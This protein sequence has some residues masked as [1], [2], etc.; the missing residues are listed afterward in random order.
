LRCLT[1]ED[2]EEFLDSASRLLSARGAGGRGTGL[3]GAEALGLVRTFEPD[4]ALV[5]VQ[6]G[7]EDG[8][9]VTP[10]LVA[11]APDDLRE[12]SPNR[13]R[14]LEPFRRM[15]RGH[16]NI[17][18]LHRLAD[19]QSALGGHVDTTVAEPAT[20]IQELQLGDVGTARALDGGTE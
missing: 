15:R 9:E 6:L 12:L 14:C 11:I 18:D 4:V 2:N 7:D 5:D 17:D 10:R 20:A 19:E 13:A 1:V 16:P 8:L 3:L